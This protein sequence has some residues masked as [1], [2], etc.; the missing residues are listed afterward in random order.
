MAAQFAQQRRGQDF[1]GLDRQD[2]LHHVLPVGF[3]QQPVDGLGEQRVDMAV[4]DVLLRPIEGH[5]MPIAHPRKQLDPQQ[6]RQPEDRLALSLGVGVHGVRLQV[7]SVF[8]EGIEDINGFPHTAGD[9]LAEQRDV[10]RREVMVGDAAVAAITDMPLAEQVVLPQFHLG[11]IG[12]R[13]VG[14]PPEPG[15]LEADVHV[16]DVSDR[17]FQLVGIDVLGIDPV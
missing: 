8:Q 3:D 10:G 11:T 6:V 5:V 7:G 9:E 16:D 15:Q 1:A 12:N 17:G 14:R 2:D 13:D 4:D